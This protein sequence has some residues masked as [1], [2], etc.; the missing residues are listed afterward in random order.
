MWHVLGEVEASSTDEIACDAKVPPES[1]WFAGHFPG[2]PILPGIAQLGIV[3]DAVC[4]SRGD[5]P[6]I[7]GFSRVKFRK[8][9]RPGDCLKIAIVPRKGHRGAYTFR[10]ST[11][12]EI[13]CSGNLALRA[14]DD[15]SQQ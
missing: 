6:G 10:I 12:E 8:I 14:P 13:A 9:I 1:L 5:K 2:D 7:A 4:R 3:Y 15:I 11:G